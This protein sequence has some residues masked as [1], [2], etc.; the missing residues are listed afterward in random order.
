MKMRVGDMEFE[1]D[2]V[3][4]MHIIGAVPPGESRPK[5]W[6]PTDEDYQSCLERYGYADIIPVFTKDGKDEEF[7]S[8][9][10]TW[11]TWCILLDLNPRHFRFEL[12]E[13]IH[14]E[15]GCTHVENYS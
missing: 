8:R 10:R 9:M 7:T 12:N 2:R 5:D 6:T 4:Q 1:Y 11:Q 15:R 14:T 3:V 13:C